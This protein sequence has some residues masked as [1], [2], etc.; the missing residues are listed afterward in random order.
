M[1]ITRTM[2]SLSVWVIL[3][4]MCSSNIFAEKE[5]EMNSSTVIVL[6]V[7]HPVT[8]KNAALFIRSILKFGGTMKD[9]PIYVINDALAKLD[10]DPVKL[11]GVSIFD[12]EIQ[13]EHRAFP[14]SRKVH[15]CATA[16]K[17]LDGK[18]ATMLYFD[19]E[20]LAFSSF[21]MLQLQKG[22]DLSLRPVMLLNTVGQSPESPID[23]FWQAIYDDAGVDSTNIPT[24]R[25]YV[26]EK[27]IRFY[28]NC[29]AM[30]LRPE[31][32]ICRTW[33]KMFVKRLQDPQFMQ[34]YCND[35]LHAIFLHQA[36]L[37][38]VLLTKVSQEKIQWIPDKTIYSVLLHDRLPKEKQVA[39][40]NSVP[41]AGYDLQFAHDPALITKVPTEE[42]YRSWVIDTFCALLQET[43]GVYREEGDCNTVVITTK[44]GYILIDPSKP[45]GADSWLALK[46]GKKAPEAV[47]FT[48]AHQDHWN[49]LQY[50]NISDNTP[51]IMHREWEKSMRYPKH[52][53][54]FYA[55]R[56]AAFTG[57]QW[58]PS[59]NLPEPIP[60]IT[61]I[62]TWSKKIAGTSVQLTHTPAESSDTSVI[63]FPEYKTACIGDTIGQAFPML[64]TPRGS[65]PRFAD[66]YIAAI[67]TILAL[68]PE[69]LITGHGPALHGIETIT[70]TLTTHKEA[71]EYVNRAVIK[72]INDGK[73]V[74]TLIR[75]IQLPK[76]LQLPEGFGKISWAIRAMYQNYTGW[77]DENPLSLL[78]EPINSAYGEIS[79]LCGINALLD[80]A[81]KLLAKDDC[82]GALYLSDIVMHTEPKNSR[83]LTLRKNA[84]ETLLKRTSN[85]GESNLLKHEINRIKK[86]L[87]SSQK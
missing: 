8:V 75:E 14:F 68:Q 16:E 59:K 30:T 52:F 54:H 36:V 49:G 28:I 5:A 35:Q 50:W 71:I 82:N 37:S 62:D 9:T 44:K 21:A 58:M 29:E 10:L 47:L 51:V 20:M 55:R 6:Y 25:A 12:M 34:T 70:K 67:D 65:L 85:W 43:P 15:A 40:L 56:N 1:T 53:E 41:I 39:T 69:V 17:L 7:T 64:G 80:R 57:G 76:H 32:G 45:R 81:E 60:T 27:D 38:A 23:G 83:A 42:P 19:T 26:D 87:D 46:F 24:I 11:P 86:I 78:D 84:C 79:S 2:K 33:Q 4:A 13:P 31:L 3:L 22:Y 73:D 18:V 66:D 72:G 74:Y 61:F 77:Y 48:H 63:W